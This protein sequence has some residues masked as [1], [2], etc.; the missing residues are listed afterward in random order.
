[1]FMQSK[2]NRKQKNNLRENN[3]REINSMFKNVEKLENQFP[4][5]C[6]LGYKTIEKN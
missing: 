6:F 4:P 1:M 5:K 3:L 2:S